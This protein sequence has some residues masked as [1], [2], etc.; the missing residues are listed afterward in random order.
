MALPLALSLARILDQ[1]AP[2]VSAYPNPAAS[3]LPAFIQRRYP[4]VGRNYIEAHHLTPISSLTGRPTNM[5][6]SDFVVVCA[7]CH[8]MLHSA[9]PP[10]APAALK[11]GL[12]PP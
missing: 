5:G 3:T 2:Q 4:S 7:N 12:G 6:V 10:L 8:R 11:T 9:N 1:Y